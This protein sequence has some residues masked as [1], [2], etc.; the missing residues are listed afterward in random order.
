MIV[1]GEAVIFGDDVNTDV[2]IPGRYLT[3]LD[4]EE[5]ARHAMEGLDPEFPSKARRGVI[6]VAGKN[7]GCGSSREQAPIALKYAGVR[8]VLAESFARIFYRNAINI[9]LPVLECPGILREVSPGDNLTVNLAEGKVR[10]DTKGITLEALKL[11]DFL[12]SIIRDGGLIE[13][14]KRRLGT[15]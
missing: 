8:C 11:P 2:I 15:A 3:T 5:L 4:P 14:L 12:L 7:F 9:G 1:K 13:H 6:I 10:N